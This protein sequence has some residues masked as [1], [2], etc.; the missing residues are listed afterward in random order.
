LCNEFSFSHKLSHESNT[1]GTGGRRRKLLNRYLFFHDLLSID[2]PIKNLLKLVEAIEGVL[3]VPGLSR[4]M[5]DFWRE[6][7]WIS[8]LFCVPV[9]FWIRIQGAP[10]KK[11]PNTVLCH[12]KT[13]T[14]GLGW[15][16][17]S[18]VRS[19]SSRFRYWPGET[20][21]GEE[22]KYAHIHQKRIVLF[23][24]SQANQDFCLFS[25]S[26]SAFSSSRVFLP[27]QI[28]QVFIKNTPQ[29][30]GFF[31]AARFFGF[32]FCEVK[33]LP[34]AADEMGGACRRQGTIGAQFSTTSQIY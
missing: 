1:C 10:Q 4:Q 9:S 13:T 24:S 17:S 29:L 19:L 8:F 7:R 33:L 12:K 14:T 21:K 3:T 30:L 32:Q 18:P 26:S 34:P 27:T 15:S 5:P 6:L 16:F 22:L 31:F 25:A 11:T 23:L 28:G 2:S 20:K